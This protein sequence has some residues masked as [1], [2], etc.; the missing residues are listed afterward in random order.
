[1]EEVYLPIRDDK[2]ARLL[3]SETVDDE[4]EEF[5]KRLMNPMEKKSVKKV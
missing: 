2:K 1:M 3:S 4:Q 5:F